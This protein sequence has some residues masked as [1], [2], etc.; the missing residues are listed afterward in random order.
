MDLHSAMKSYYHPPSSLLSDYVRNILVLDGQSQPDLPVFT[1]GVPAL[2]CRI[3][4]DVIELTLFGKSIPDDV[5][6]I[7]DD[8]I[9][10][11]FFFK[12]FSVAS[13]FDIPAV[14]LAKEVINLFQWDAHKMNALKI[15]LLSAENTT[16]KI[17]GLGHFLYRQLERNRKQCE[18]IRYAT[19]EIMN[20]SAPEA[21]T[22]VLEKLNVN[23]RTFQRMFRKLVGITPNQYRRICQFQR[24]FT[25]VRAKSFETLAEVAFDNG[26]ADQSHF[27]RSFK[28]FTQLTPNDYIRSGLKKE[29]S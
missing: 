9:H 1:N 5:L 21:L 27:I 16:Q 24:S 23:Q 20:D 8:T 14:T 22:S 2:V 11:I 13:L 6:M 15:Q 3:K 17:D 10:I 26:F 29:N 25:Q 12:P 18:L 28:E 19:D 7:D 4:R